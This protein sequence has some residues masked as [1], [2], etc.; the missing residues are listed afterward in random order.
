MDL[1]IGLTTLEFKERIFDFSETTEWKFKGERPV[2]IEFGADWC[3]PC[4]MMTPTL[5]E[6]SE[7]Y[8]GKVD[9][10]RVDVDVE[11]DLAKSFAIQSVP[12]FLFIPLKGPPTTAV[13][14]AAKE[15]LV[16]AIDNILY[17]KEKE[18]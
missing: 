13:G 17:G 12:T 15:E 8:K 11:Q 1:D 16:K 4:Q 10:H 3:I 18:G 2:V 5:I 7:E 6:L 14:S 9:I